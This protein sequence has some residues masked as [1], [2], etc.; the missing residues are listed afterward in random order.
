MATFIM[1]RGVKHRRCPLTLS[2]RSKS[3]QVG[4]HLVMPT[5]PASQSSVTQPQGTDLVLKL[6]VHFHILS[7][8]TG[9]GDNWLWFTSSSGLSAA[10]WPF[11]ASIT[12]A[13]YAR[14]T[15]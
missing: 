3:Q 4:R 8:E 11:E 10:P 12:E 7:A 9:A 14:C 1:S 13:I 15:V 5:P 2:T 6:G